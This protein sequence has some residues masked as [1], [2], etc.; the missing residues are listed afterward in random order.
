MK[1]KIIFFLSLILSAAITSCKKE[2]PD[3]PLGLRDLSISSCK[4]KGEEAKGIDDPEFISIKTID[5]YYILFKHVNSMFNCEPGQITISLEIEA[6]TILI[7]EKE[8]TSLAN[9]VC[10]YDLEFRL[11]PLQYGEYL[12]RFQK[13]GS[14][15]KE[16]TLNFR[17][18]TDVVVEI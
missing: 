13:G 15:L 4:S 7:D 1:T 6:D 11:G 17:K 8:E 10:Q 18:S 9:C 2:F 5:D 14:L 12:I 16:Y 3:D